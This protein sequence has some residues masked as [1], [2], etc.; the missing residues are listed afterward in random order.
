MLKSIRALADEKNSGKM[1]GEV[2]NRHELREVSYRWDIH[3]Y[4]RKGV[5]KCMSNANGEIL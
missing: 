2:F 1:T 5:N 4:D 3:K